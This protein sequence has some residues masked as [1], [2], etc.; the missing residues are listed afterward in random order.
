MDITLTYSE[1]EQYIANHYHQ[2]VEFKQAGDTAVK[3]T[4]HTKIPLLGTVSKDITLTITEVEAHAITVRYS[5]GLLVD[6]FIVDGIINTVFD[7]IQN[8]IG[9]GIRKIGK[10]TL[11]IDLALIP[12]A[13]ALADALALRTITTHA[14]TLHINAALL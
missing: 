6:N 14:D 10:Q 3:A 2:R 13:K 11:L 4:V 1:L 5:A 7:V 9:E 12:Q 8:A